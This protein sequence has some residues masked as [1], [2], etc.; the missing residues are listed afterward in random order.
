M[1]ILEYLNQGFYVICG[2]CITLCLMTIAQ[3]FLIRRLT[4]TIRE[5]ANANDRL[6]EKTKEIIY[7]V[8]EYGLNYTKA[9]IEFAEF[10][11][12]DEIKNTSISNN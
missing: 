6:A 10:C 8:R 4:V 5:Q 1:E 3:H 7:L 9:Q 12:E 11:R 2:F